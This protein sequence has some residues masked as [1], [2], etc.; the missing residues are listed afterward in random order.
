MGLTLIRKSDG[1]R[2]VANPKVRL[3][4]RTLDEGPLLQ[5]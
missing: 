2:P 5:T 1:T 4:N 3:R